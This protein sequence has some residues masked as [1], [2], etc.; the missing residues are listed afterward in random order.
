M[1]SPQSI[2]IQKIIADRGLASR[3]EAERWIEEGRVTVNGELVELGAKCMPGKDT[4][5]VDGR[6]ISRRA[7]IKVEKVSPRHTRPGEAWKQLEVTLHHG[8]KREIRRLFYAFGYDVRKLR[9]VQIGQ[10]RLK[11]L[12]RGHIKTLSKSEIRQLFEP[13]KP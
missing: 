1:K 11:G 3:R 2:R 7:P 8:K 9:R 12:P 6:V 13:E 4:I 10:L 5:A